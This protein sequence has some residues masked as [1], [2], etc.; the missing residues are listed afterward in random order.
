MDRWM[1]RVLAVMWAAAGVG[2]FSAQVSAALIDDMNDT[3]LAEYTL[4]KVLD[5]GAGTSNISFA[6]PS[7]SLLVGSSGTTGA[8]QVLLL[9]DDASLAVGDMLLADVTGT[10]A[11]WDRDIGI[12][13]GFTKTPTG[14]GDPAAGDVRTTYVEV[15]ARANNQIVAFA[16]NGAANLTSGQEFAGTT[17]GGVSFSVA[18]PISLYIARLATNTFE[19]GWIQG[20][21]RHAITANGTAIMPY[22]ITDANVPGAAVGFYADVR[23]N[24]ASS[25]VGL[26]NL[27][28]IPI[29]EPSA[30]ALLAA[31]LVPMRRR[32]G[33]PV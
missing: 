23:A 9:R 26:D 13:V 20:S 33:R 19:V 15:S 10:W 16:R 24:L 1:M 21:T 27:R 3:S 30:L 18:N 17:Y 28:T 6:S 8:E 32:R 4:T 25:P 14:L 31:A 5:Q 2:G 11:N 29:P 7:G 22:T 12:A